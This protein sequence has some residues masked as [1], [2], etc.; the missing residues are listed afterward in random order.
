MVGQGGSAER[1]RA[2]RPRDAASLVL[3]RGS[4]QSPEVLLGRRPAS[5]R[6]M[7]GVYVF[8]GG[9]VE[10]GDHAV[11]AAFEIRADVLTRLARHGGPRRAKALSWAAI[12]E[13][14]EET[15]LMLGKAGRIPGTSRSAARQAFAAMGLVP[16]LAALDY[17]AR[18]VTPA[19]SPIRFDTRF[20]IADGAGARGTLRETGELED[21]GW[22]RVEEALDRF[23]LM[24]VTR[25]VLAEARRYWAERPPPDPDR[26]VPLLTRRRGT[27][28]VGHD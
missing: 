16:D 11:A 3:L 23:E 27:R 8:P 12:R 5:A 2:V 15:G 1:R 28:I 25:F 18:A 4:R 24:G 17:I 6:F 20:F 22:R 10:R 14:W 13:T 9:A 7:P 19:H 26:P 21:I